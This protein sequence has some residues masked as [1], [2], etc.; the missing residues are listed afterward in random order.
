MAK[1]MADRD[2]LRAAEPGVVA[3]APNRGS[4]ML[5]TSVL[6]K[7]MVLRELLPQDIKLEIYKFSSGEA[8]RAAR[9][10]VYVVGIAHARQM[11]ATDRA[12]WA[13]VIAQGQSEYPARLSCRRDLTSRGFYRDSW[14]GLFKWPSKA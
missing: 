1:A 11:S 7:S 5:A 6:G 10:R 14:V 13:K 9:Y 2:V 3:L 12:R 4:R 8:T